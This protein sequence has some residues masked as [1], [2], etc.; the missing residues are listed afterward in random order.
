VATQRDRGAT[1][2]QARLEIGR[3]IGGP[4]E[5]ERLTQLIGRNAI[6]QID[7]HETR[8]PSGLRPRCAREG[9]GVERAEALLGGGRLERPLKPE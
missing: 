4:T 9:H 7:R 5:H 2:G 3:R 1:R 6:D 8:R